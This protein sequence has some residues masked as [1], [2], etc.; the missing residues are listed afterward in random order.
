MDRVSLVRRLGSDLYRLSPM[1]HRYAARLTALGSAILR[2]RE[3]L[4]R[5]SELSL[6]TGV[7]DGSMIG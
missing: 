7:L 1:A 3:W 2:N 6:Q 4:A 5:V